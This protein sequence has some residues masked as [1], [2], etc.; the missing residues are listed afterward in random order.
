MAGWWARC[1]ETRLFLGV[2]TLARVFF[3]LGFLAITFFLVFALGARI[4]F[5][6]GLFFFL[7]MEKV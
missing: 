4:D 6:L 5:F 1:R 2:G 3:G 7:A